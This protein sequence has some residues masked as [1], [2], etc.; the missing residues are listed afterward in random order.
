M[1]LSDS[2][3][4]LSVSERE[5][6][7]LEAISKYGI[8]GHDLGIR[9]TTCPPRDQGRDL[10]PQDG[11]EGRGFS[12]TRHRG[13]RPAVF[14]RM[15]LFLLPVR[16]G[17]YAIVRGEGYIDIPE[18]QT[19][20][21]PHSPSTDFALQSSLVGDSEMQHLDYA[22]ASGML[23]DFVGM[24]RLYLTI[25]GRKYT[26]SDGFGFRVGEVELEARSVQTEVDAGRGQGAWFWSRGRTRKSRHHHPAAVL[27]VPEM[28]DRH[29][30]R[31][32]P[33]SE[34]GGEYMFWMYYFEDP[35]DYNSI[36]MV[37]RNRIGLHDTTLLFLVTG[38]FSSASSTA[39]SPSAP[40]SWPSSRC[41]S[42]PS[43]S[44]FWASSGYGR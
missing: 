9:R 40:T 10:P 23:E 28:V 1:D 20:P 7:A 37:R 35:V 2:V 31:V 29:D 12:A 21:I 3:T 18:I 36:R 33:S 44:P 6:R 17:E 32:I 8:H 11:S 13:D 27:P 15:G 25:R 16:N 26:P 43:A 39:A 14:E 38:S 4:A 42:P 19:S 24:G 41:P 34:T 5:G 22:H 30:K